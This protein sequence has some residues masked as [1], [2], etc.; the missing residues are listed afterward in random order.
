VPI[1]N[2]RAYQIALQLSAWVGQ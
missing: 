2:K 1:L